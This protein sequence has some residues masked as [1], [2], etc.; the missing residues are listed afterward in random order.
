MANSVRGVH[1]SPGIYSR[2]EELNFSAKSLGITTLGLVG[3]TQRGPAFQPVSI[4]NWR[5]FQSTFGGTSTEKFKDTQYPKYELPYIAKSY[6]SESNQLEVCR[7]LGLSGYNAGPAWIVTASGS[8]EYDNSAVL[9]LRSRGYYDKFYKPTGGAGLDDCVCG[10]VQYDYQRFLVGEDGDPSCVGAIKG[11]PFNLNTVKLGKYTPIQSNEN[12]CNGSTIDPDTRNFQVSPINYGKFNIYVKL[13]DDF[14]N[15]TNKYTGGTNVK[16]H[17]K[18]QFENKKVTFESE[19]Y[20]ESGA[21]EK[22]V[23]LGDDKYKITTSGSKITKVGEMKVEDDTFHY[24]GFDY[25]VSGVASVKA[26]VEVEENDVISIYGTSYIVNYS[27]GDTLTIDSLSVVDNVYAVSLNPS[28][29]DYILKVLGT[30]NHDGSAPLYVEAL[31][32]VALVQG[33]ESEKISEINH[34]LTTVCPTLISDANR[35]EPVSDLMRKPEGSLTRADVGKRFLADNESKNLVIY[36]HTVNDSG[37]L[38]QS[39]SGSSG[40]TEMTSATT[41]DTFNLSN[42]EVKLVESCKVYVVKQFT[43]SDGKR[44]YFYVDAKEKLVKNGTQSGTTTSAYTDASDCALKFDAKESNTGD[45]YSI[46][47]KVNSNGLYYRYAKLNSEGEID[48]TNGTIDTVLPVLLDMNNYKSQYRF[49]S[50]PW[51][52]SNVKGDYNNVEVNRLFRFHTISDG[53]NANMEVKVSIEDI[54]VEDGTFTVIVRDINDSDESIMPLEKF[55]RCTMVPGDSKFIGFKI[56]TADGEYEQVSKYITV[57]LYTPNNGVISQNSVPCGFLGYPHGFG[58]GVAILGVNTPIVPPVLKYNCHFD[59]DVKAR[60][61]YFGLSSKVGVDLDAFTFKGVNAYVES[62]EY[63]SNGFHLDCRMSGES[64]KDSSINITVDS[65]EGFT[66]DTV[67]VNART[68]VYDGNPIIGT[69]EEMYG[70]IFEDIKLRKFTTYFYGGFD[71]WDEY[72]QS[73]TNT[74]D[75]KMTKYRGQY[76]EA[77]GEGYSFDAIKDPEALGLNQK[78]L[79]SDWYAYL[80][81]YRQFANPE[82]VDCNLFATPGIDLINNTLLSQEVIEMLEEERADSLYV[83]TM[84]DKPSG[85]N[86]YV[87]EMYSPEDIVEALEDTEIDSN[88]TCTYYPWVKYFDQDNSQYIYL[89]PTKDVVRNMAQTDNVSYSWF[90]PAGLE[91]GDV[92]A[93]RAH[94]VTRLADEDTLYE[95]RINPI[96]TFAQ[97]GIKV[98]GQKTL[99]VEDGQLNRIAVRR[100][101]LRMRKMIAVACLGL[102][103]TPNDAQTKQSLQGIIANVMDG[104]R[105]SRGITDYRIEITSSN[106]TNEDRR[107]LNCRI[108]FKVISALEYINLT[109]SITPEGV[110]FD[111]I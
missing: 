71:G 110:S 10:T 96:K 69:E 77:S 21:T 13:S 14:T 26:E 49:A 54:S 9:V 40:V 46:L 41:A 35:I 83:A 57:E 39:P 16:E 4:E 3:E 107:E 90:A 28:D 62:P 53:N 65:E 52:V 106:V 1:V 91:R 86:D 32:D 43:T 66:F 109:F 51:F 85:A 47:V 2:E 88:Y 97:D 37:N 73:R 60:K 17:I 24:N 18:V 44:H 59:E 103:F 92:Q 108:L 67:S 31:Y 87:D 111:D 95:G 75:F 29:N 64:Y 63:M 82:S 99:Q 93:T 89:P 79:T 33:I 55:S 6:L 94:Y 7:V 15:D 98:W 23:N 48:N 70:C 19:V 38:N 104:I 11:R 25:T 74:D 80:A 105:A 20:N 68:S 5:D 45:T 78:G 100:L 8:G 56:G 81:A 36:Y 84:P 34:T 12:L 50:T 30:N 102:I 76:N 58:N 72:R 22:F 42:Y 101:L 61:Q 27:D